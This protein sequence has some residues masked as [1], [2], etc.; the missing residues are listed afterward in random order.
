LGEPLAPFTAMSGP[1]TSPA[2]WL[3]D[4][5]ACCARCSVNGGDWGWFA[6]IAAYTRTGWAICS[7]LW[8]DVP[9]ELRGAFRWLDQGELNERWR[10]DVLAVAVES[11]LP[12]TDADRDLGRSLWRQVSDDVDV[13]DVMQQL[14]AVLGRAAP[15]VM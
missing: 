11:G 13:W 1:C 14:L 12:V 8:W 3:S 2:V 15:D 7:D 6:P 5:E 4:G 9:P 10:E